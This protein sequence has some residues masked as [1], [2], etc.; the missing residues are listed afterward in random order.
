[1]SSFILLLVFRLVGFSLVASTVYAPYYLG[2]CV[3]WYDPD[4]EIPAVKSS[5][6]SKHSLTWS[7]LVDHGGSLN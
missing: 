6:V 1:M 3:S 7:N 5:Y 2:D 4:Y